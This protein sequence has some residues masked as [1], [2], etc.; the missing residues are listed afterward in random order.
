[1][2]SVTILEE[3]RLLKAEIKMRYVSKQTM[4]RA[5]YLKKLQMTTEK[6]KIA[7]D[8]LKTNLQ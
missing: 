6:S 2:N 3:L 7:L 5:Q 4:F 1:M 8:P